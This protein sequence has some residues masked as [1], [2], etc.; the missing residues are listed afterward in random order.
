MSAQDAAA[1][2]QS[3]VNAAAAFRCARL[4]ERVAML[5]VAAP[6]LVAQ[7][8]PPGGA[9]EGTVINSATGAGIGGAL[10]TFFGGS[11][12]RYSSTSDAV[13]HFKITG[14]TPGTY[15]ASAEKDGFS[16]FALDIASLLSNP[17][18]PV[19]ASPDPLR[20]DLK[21]APLSALRG[22]VF[23]PDGKPVAGIQVNL[24]P[25][26]LGSVVTDEEGRFALEQVKLGSYTLSARPPATAAPVEAEDGTR[27]AMVTTYFPSVA[28]RSLA[29][30]IMF[31]GEGD[32]DGYDI[33]MQTASVHRLRGIV[34]DE[35]G[36]PLSGAELILLPSPET[37]LGPMGL[38][39]AAVGS[40]FFLT[41]VRPPLSGAPE[42]TVDSGKDGRFEFPAVQSGDWR[43]D[44]QSN[45]T[46]TAEARVRREDVDDLQIH[47]SMPFKVIGAVEWAEGDPGGQRISNGRLRFPLMTL[48]SA[49]TDEFVGSGF[50]ESGKIS[51]DKVLPGRYKAI[52]KPGLSAR[53]FLGE[54]EVTGQPFPLAANGPPL[55]V[56]P[57]TWSGSVHGIVENGDGATV[58]LVPQQNEGPVIGQTIRCGSGGSFELNEVSPGDYFIAAFDRMDGLFPSAAM[59][60]VLPSRGTSVRVE[61][62]S[63]A[64]VMLSVVQA[65]K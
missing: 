48:L 44:V 3:S 50:V 31:R 47:V 21:L 54:A 64:S 10:V 14:M 62:G 34:L 63:A 45:P 1:S 49:D 15:R 55:R 56:I 46:G 24:N 19:T 51:F 35:E 6:L 13:G 61:E 37:P 53:I 60:N 32:L 18:F 16:T 39:S 11:S 33:R 2:S 29:Q 58:V 25:N 26:M 59:L 30:Q 23:G 41:G 17:G 8:A 28:D 57:K 27:T 65:P 38:G 42:A 5:V 43:I 36:K 52:V 22:R 12:A 20:V 40:S 7:N 9:V 4:L